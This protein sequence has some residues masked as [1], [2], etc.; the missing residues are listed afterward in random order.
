M[1]KLF[2][3]LKPFTLPLLAILILL[4]GQAMADLYLPTLMADIV[5]TG[6]VKNDTAY[7]WRV[8]ELMLGV[9]AIG[10][11]CAV[12]G[13]FL[14]SQLAVGFGRNVRGMV[15]TQVTDYSLREFDKLGTATLITR[16]TN[17]INQVQ[18]AL[19]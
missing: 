17:D 15:F 8:G 9:A 10:G 13:A 12:V 19:L 3:N 7:I 2:R 5:D 11:V 16:T 6:I 18:M 14:S 4:F 1:L